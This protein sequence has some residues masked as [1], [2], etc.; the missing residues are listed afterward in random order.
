[1]L[2]QSGERDD[3]VPPADAAAYQ[4]AANELAKVVWYDAGHLLNRDA[5]C[6]AAV[7]LGEHLGFDGNAAA[8]CS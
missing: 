1:V 7:W 4:A 2:F 5:D 8:P 6:D 3:V